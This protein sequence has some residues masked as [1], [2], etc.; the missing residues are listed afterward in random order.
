MARAGRGY[1][2][3]VAGAKVV[4]PLLALALLAT[5]FLIARQIDPD[6]A[7]PYAEVD[8]EQFAREARIG[9][10]EFS[11]VTSDGTVVSLAA[12]VARPDPDRPG[13]ITA[14]GIAA[15][16]EVPDG[17]LIEARAG[18]AAVDGAAQR[19]ELSGGVLLSTSTGY[20][21]TVAGVT[22]GLGVTDIVSHGPVQA[23]GPPGRFEA[24]AAQIRQTSED[25]SVYVLVFNRGVKLI[26]EPGK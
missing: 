2:R 5:M 3:F 8:V 13:R 26:Y 9:A 21:I 12:E 11:G 23:E 25:P 19:L 1:S 17:S 18:R 22:A 7:L 6:A 10:P 4:L 15:I 24:G 20:R 16:F 14:E